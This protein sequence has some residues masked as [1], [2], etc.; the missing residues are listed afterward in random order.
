MKTHVAMACLITGVLLCAGRAMPAD[1]DTDR[2][3]PGTF[4][5]DSEIT[6]KVK[7][8]LT[9]DHASNLARV[10]VDTDQNGEVWLSGT[11][12][13]QMVAERAV[14]LAKSTEGVKAVH[15]EIKVKAED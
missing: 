10:H 11:V 4:V 1:S 8:K 15:D 2:S 14:S 7:A 6:T 5:K 3:H 13:S 12:E 9:A